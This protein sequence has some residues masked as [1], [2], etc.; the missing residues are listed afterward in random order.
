MPEPFF[1]KVV[2]LRS[3]TLLKER[4][5]QR[6]FP[7]IFAKFLRKLFFNRTPPVPASDL[8]KLLPIQMWF[9]PPNLC[10]K[11]PVSTHINYHP[12][13]RQI[14]L[15]TKKLLPSRTTS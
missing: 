15:C 7:M 6:C 1:N 10:L 3:A 12:K 13:L 9:D 8:L 11:V 5:R 2:G 14:P 4:L